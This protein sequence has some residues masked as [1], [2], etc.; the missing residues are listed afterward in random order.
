L[1]NALLEFFE[2]RT[3]LSI[4]FITVGITSLFGLL[5]H[6]LGPELSSAI[7]YIIPITIAAW[8]GSYRIGIA[9]CFLAAGFWLLSDISSGHEY[10]HPSTIYWNGF[11]RLTLF[12]II[13]HLFSLFRERL[14]V[15]EAAADTDSLTGAANFRGFYAQLDRYVHHARRYKHPLT[16]AYFDLDNFKTVNDTLGHSA[17]DQLLITVVTTLTQHMRKTDIIARLGGDEFA[18]LL[19]ETSFAD[20]NSAFQHA[21]QQ[22]QE[23]MDSNNWPVTFSVGMVTFNELT[24]STKEMIKIV[25]ELMYG[26]KKSQKNALCHTSWPNL[27][28]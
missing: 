10:S 21:H 2:E 18:V 19:T 15:E 8:F 25:D 12:L 16:L 20:A 26:V 24:E 13:S 5:D 17:G 1:I 14:R 4:F 7:F 9:I 3:P 22:L 11:V 28:N 6:F 23:A 27:E